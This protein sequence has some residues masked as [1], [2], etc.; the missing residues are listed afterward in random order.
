RGGSMG[1]FF[2]HGDLRFV[3]LGLI[4]DKPGHG[5]EL[6]KAIEDRVG[7][8]YSPSPGVIYP[9]LTLL[10]E[11]G[12][13]T[14][15]TETG[16]RKL[17]AITDEGLAFL[18]ANR[19]TVT[20]VFARMDEAGERRGGGT[21]PQIVRAIENLKLTVRLRLDR[22]PL[23]EAETETIAKALDDAAATIERS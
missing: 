9:T 12:Y 16:P 5:Y 2:D 15:S 14:V 11:L 17:Y 3:I 23:S 19:D 20:A 21:A 22:G 4:A 10:D 1:R 7:G 8:A 18:E 6:I 13:V